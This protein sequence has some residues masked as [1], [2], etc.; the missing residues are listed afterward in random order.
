MN[1]RS[2][3]G[4]AAWRMHVALSAMLLLGAGTM[5]ALADPPAAQATATALFA[6][7]VTTGPGWDKAKPPG[8]QAFFRE[9]SAHLKRLRDEGRIVVGARYSDKGLLVFRATSADEVRAW[10]AGDPSMQAGTF[11]SE[12][13]PFNVFYPGQLDAPPRR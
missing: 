13:H 11:A 3:P 7:E 8:E 12:V 2:D 9:H 6:V 4:G 1:T 10:M 5:G